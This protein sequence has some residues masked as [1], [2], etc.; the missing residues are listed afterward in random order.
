MQALMEVPD[1]YSS[2][3]S[4]GLLG[5]VPEN[6][7]PQILVSEP[8]EDCYAVLPGTAPM[9]WSAPIPLDG[10]VYLLHLDFPSLHCSRDVL[11][12]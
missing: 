9:C 6:P 4:R 3:L 2:I 1:Q 12:V 5:T 11:A 8:P 7:P 10:L